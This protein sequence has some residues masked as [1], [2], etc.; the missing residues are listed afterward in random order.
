MKYLDST[1]VIEICIKTY[2]ISDSQ[3]MI[4]IRHLFPKLYEFNPDTSLLFK[5]F[6]FY[7]RLDLF[8]ETLMLRKRQTKGVKIKVDQNENFEGEI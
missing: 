7:D 4:Q 1:D 5:M 2:S 6:V 3:I 8:E